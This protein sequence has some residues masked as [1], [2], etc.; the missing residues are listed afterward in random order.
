MPD[1]VAL[2]ADNPEHEWQRLQRDPFR[3]LEYDTTLHFL[4]PLL[5][6]TG[7]VLDAGG[8]PGRYAIELAR[9]GLQDRKSVVVGK[10]LY[11]G[12]RPNI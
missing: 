9:R 8:G 3:R 11:K 4:G 1:I 5:P 2:Y 10:N 6:K 7:R 12:G